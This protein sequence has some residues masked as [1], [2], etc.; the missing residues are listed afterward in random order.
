MHLKRGISAEAIACKYLESH[1]L[2]LVTKNF[3]TKCGEID[4]IM[5]DKDVIV[6]TEVRYRKNN[7]YGT[8]IATI[9]HPKQ[10]KLQ[11]AAQLYLQRT[12]TLNTVFS[13][14][15]V[16]G[17]EGSLVKPNVTW[18]KNAFYAN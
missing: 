12:H 11:N 15:D 4:L 8:P 14:F 10:R 16:V 7:N 6:F 1:G 13:R 17:I 18:I 5:R 2:R 3:R 9:N